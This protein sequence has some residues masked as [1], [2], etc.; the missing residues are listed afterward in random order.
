MPVGLILP[1]C[2]PF[3]AALPHP[4]RSFHTSLP[5]GYA[6]VLSGWC[7]GY[8]WDD[9][10]WLWTGV[11]PCPLCSLPPDMS[12]WGWGWGQFPMKPVCCQDTTFFCDN[13]FYKNTSE[14]RTLRTKITSFLEG[15]WTT[16]D[17]NYLNLNFCT[18]FLSVK[19]RGQQ[20]GWCGTTWTLSSAVCESSPLWPCSIAGLAVVV[21]IAPLCVQPSSVINFVPAKE[22]LTDGG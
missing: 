1:F 12:L 6:R 11:F 22:C 21:F 4:H 3:C 18:I 8:V 20:N 5:P 7:H 15:L 13:L 10:P 9:A 16:R 19:Y 14:L 2:L 17:W